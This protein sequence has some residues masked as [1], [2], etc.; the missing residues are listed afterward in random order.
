MALFLFFPRRRRRRSPRVQCRVKSLSQFPWYHRLRTG[1][2][3]PHEIS[4]RNL[5]PFSDGYHK[6][7]N[8]ARKI[9]TCLT[10]KGSIHKSYLSVLG[11]TTHLRLMSPCTFFFSFFFP[12]HYP[13]YL[14]TTYVHRGSH[15][16]VFFP[17]AYAPNLFTR[18]HV[19][20][21]ARRWR[22]V[23]EQPITVLFEWEQ[24]ALWLSTLLVQCDECY[25]LFCFRPSR[26]RS[27]RTETSRRN[28]VLIQKPR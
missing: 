20:V 19:E 1:N 27:E 17:P 25:F 21:D 23:L 24:T 11:K 13:P 10:V 16:F 3:S 15:A 4:K 18:H 8:T 22:L 6:N 12:S 2:S 9:F 5:F 26:P 7:P 14:T 28:L